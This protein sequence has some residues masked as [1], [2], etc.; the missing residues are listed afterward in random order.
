MSY[1]LAR[2]LLFALPTETAHALALGAADAGGSALLQR[3]WGRRVPARPVRAFGLEFANPVGLAAGLDKNADHVDA[4]GALGFGFVE[5]GTLTPRP[6]PG[7]PRPR[8]F[9]IADRQALINRMGFNNKG[10]EHA[11]ARLR[12]RRFDG[13]VGVNIGKNRD[14]PVEDALADYRFCLQRVHEVADYVTVNV[15]SPNTPGLRRLQSGP[16]LDSLL[17]PLA[18]QRTELDRDAQRRVPLLVKVAPDLDDGELRAIA[19]SVRAN[20]LDGVIAT[21]TTTDHGAVAGLR[22]GDEEGGLSGAPLADRANECLRAL[23]RELGPSFPVIGV[24]GIVDA[25]GVRAKR[26]AGARLVQLYTGLI[27]RGPSL[28]REAVEAWDEDHG[29]AN[30]RE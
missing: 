3:L 12:A 28:I 29:T 7:N 17:G 13:V 2:A 25:N 26:S 22:H 9:R 11:V 14:T 4:L 23:A 21:N 6:Q 10:V 19:D 1:R 8:L 18:E 15:S 5:I 24:G 30:G 27:Y 20:D 16:A